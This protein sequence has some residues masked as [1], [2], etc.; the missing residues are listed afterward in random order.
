M[1]IS[2]IVGTTGGVQV[3]PSQQIA[4]L[5]QSAA[6]L[7]CVLQ[8]RKNNFFTTFSRKKEQII[9]EKKDEEFDKQKSCFTTSCQTLFVNYMQRQEQCNLQFLS[10]TNLSQKKIVK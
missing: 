2:V 1:A 7:K 9:Q 8:L 6:L 3:L 10:E 4:T 5:E